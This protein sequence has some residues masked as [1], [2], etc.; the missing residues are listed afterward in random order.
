MK[1]SIDNAAQLCQLSNGVPDNVR[2]C[3]DSLDREANEALRIFEE[4]ENENKFR[5]CIDK[6]KKLGDQVVEACASAKVGRQVENAVR[7]AHEAI[8]NLK[9][10]L[11]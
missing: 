1:Q 11:H 4:E 9:H 6:L 3:L 8:S 2:S 10:R 5:Q 7:Q